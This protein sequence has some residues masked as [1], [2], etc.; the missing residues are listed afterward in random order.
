MAIPALSGTS[1]WAALCKLSVGETKV[2]TTSPVQ[3]QRVELRA[4]V[5]GTF[6]TPFD[7]DE[8][9]VDAEIMAPSGKKYSTPAFYYQRFE[10]EVR[11]GRDNTMRE[12]MTA[13]DPPEWCVR[14]MPSEAGTYTVRIAARDRSGSVSGPAVQFTTQSGAGR[15]CLRVSR[16]DPHYF[17]FDDGTP[18]FAIGE[19]LVEGPLSEYYRWIPRLSKNGGNYSR[20]WI[21]HPSFA[22]ELG[23]MGEYRMDNAWRLDQVMELS[24]EYG[25]YQKMCIDWIRHITPRGEPRKQFDVEDYAYSISNGGPCRNMRDFFTLPEARRLFRNRLRYTVARWGY[26]THVMAWE[27]WNEINAIDRE[28]GADRSVILD[29]NR[30][31]CTYLKQVDPAQHLTTNSLGSSGFWA[32][33]WQMPENEFTQ[34][35]N[36][37]GWHRPEDEELAHDMAGLALK[38]LEPLRPF[39][40]PMLFA[41]FG[42][43]REKP[44]FR[45]LCDRDTQGVHLHNGLWAPLAFGAAGTGALWWW[46]QYVDP[47]NLYFHFLPVA[48]FTADIRWTTAG[49]ERAQVEA[50]DVRVRV[51]GLR[52]K[53]VTIL[54]VQ[55]RLHTWG[56][57][58]AGKPIPRIDLV[59]LTLDG[60][61]PGRYRVEY[62]D[63]WTGAVTRESDLL[64]PQGTAVISVPQLERDI[65]LKLVRLNR[66]TKRESSNAIFAGGSSSFVSGGGSR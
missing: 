4:A 13:A 58:V 46:G 61:E 3:W 31:M 7:S 52:G 65:A 36:Y 33:M 28:V 59:R 1:K 27:L 14:L 39:R 40:K 18:Y 43:I 62:W 26:S 60:V 11:G 20:L 49:F 30:E 15:G 12:I 38:W 17:E 54:W 24:E 56:N 8:I 29:W 51:L 2:L 53:S 66:E 45:A 22:L 23:P 44:D 42:I 35:H 63:T 41:E 9:A 16:K 21:G 25:I 50:D 10:R 64:V 57:V 47:K 37:Y 34:M 19:N 48:K 32:E 55:N 6:T 5:T